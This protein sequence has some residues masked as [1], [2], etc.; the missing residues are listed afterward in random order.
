M[1]NPHILL[2][3]SDVLVRKPLAEYLRDCGY[4][5]VE[6][7]NTDEAVDLLTTGNPAIGIVLADIS[8]PGKVDGFGLAQ[9]IRSK[10]IDAKI[11][12][13]GN[14]QKAAAKAQDLCE[15]GPLL[16][17]PYDHS[18]LLNRIKSEVAARARNGKPEPDI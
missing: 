4:K 9:W 10:G 14:V 11:I 13:A 2:V 8:S 17:K 6:A 7:L 15:D 16:S 1:T 18:L 12:L 3:E 5:V